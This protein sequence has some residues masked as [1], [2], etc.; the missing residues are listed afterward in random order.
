M[1]TKLCTSKVTS[2][3]L[4]IDRNVARSLSIRR[5]IG[6]VLA[7]DAD[8]DLTADVLWQCFRVELNTATEKFIPHKFAK[9]RNGLPYLTKDIKH[10]MRKRD[11]KLKAQKGKGKTTAHSSKPLSNS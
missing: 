9:S 8:I 10:L 2:N 5:L 3:Q 11:K 1:I 6:K 4:Y 7:T